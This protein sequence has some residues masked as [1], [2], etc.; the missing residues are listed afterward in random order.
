MLSTILFTASLSAGQLPADVLATYAEL[1]KTHLK[2]GQ[3]AYRKLAAPPELAKLDRVVAAIGAASAPAGKDA[4]IAFYIDAYNALVLRAVIAA[5]MPR[6][7]L[8]VKGFFDQQQHLVAQKKLTLNQLEK[9]L[10]IPLAKPD[11]RPHMVLV[12]AAAGCPILEGT[13]YSGGDL[14]ARL[15]AASRRYLASPRGAIFGPNEVKLSKIFDW[16]KADFGGDA[17]VLAFVRKYGPKAEVA[18]LGDQPKVAYIDYNWTL[19]QQ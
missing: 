18:A 10:L 2:D 15:A 17:G 1:L 19:N 16:Y 13:P 12:C 9:E 8:D 4:A 11:P 7:V 14:E 5:K 3:I 6:S